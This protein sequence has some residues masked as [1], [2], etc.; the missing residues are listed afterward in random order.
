MFL[1]AMLLERR[2][3]RELERIAARV[4]EGC[5][6]EEFSCSRCPWCGLPVDIAFSPEGNGFCIACTGGLSRHFGKNYAIE[7][8]PPWWREHVGLTTT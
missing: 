7:N 4:Q 5:S 8:P 6:Y 2:R 1:K 3:R